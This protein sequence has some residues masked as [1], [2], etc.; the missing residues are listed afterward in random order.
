VQFFT[1]NRERR[2]LTVYPGS[3]VCNHGCTTESLESDAQRQGAVAADAAGDRFAVD[4]SGLNID[5]K[6]DYP[7]LIFAF[8]SQYHVLC[9][10]KKFIM[11]QVLIGM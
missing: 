7:V 10:K 2:L 5:C 3:A 1:P 11:L 4:W 6:I 9:N 8:A